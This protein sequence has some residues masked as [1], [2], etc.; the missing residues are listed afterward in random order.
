VLLCYH[1]IE[2]NVWMSVL[3]LSGSVYCVPT[4]SY[5]GPDE[6]ATKIVAYVK[7]H[8][9]KETTLVEVP[10]PFHDE[11]I[12]LDLYRTFSEAMAAECVKAG[13]AKMVVPIG[14]TLE[15]WN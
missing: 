10:S 13:M 7:Q 15:D 6:L 2:G 12:T 5:S 14:M 11:Q 9:A 4:L 1:T 3:I 8:G